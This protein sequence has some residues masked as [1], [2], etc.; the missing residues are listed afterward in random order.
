LAKTAKKLVLHSGRHQRV[1]RG[2]AWVFSNEAANLRDGFEP[3]EEVDVIAASGQV[4]GRGY[5]NPHSLI[6][7]RLVRREA[8]ELDAAFFAERLE[9]ARRLREELYPGDTC[10]RLVYGESDGLPGLVIDRYGE[11]YV[12]QAP[13]AGM[14]RLLP[15]VLEALRH[16][17]EPASVILRNDGPVVDL[18]GLEREKRVLFGAFPRM[19]EV[20]LEGMALHVD[21]WEGQ[22]TGLYLDQRENRGV[23]RGVAPGARVLDCFAYCGLW[24]L[25][26]ARWGAVDCLALDSSARALAWAAD[27]AARNGLAGRCRFEKADVFTHLDRLGRRERF[28]VV[29]LDPPALAH[30]GAHL[31]K[32]RSAYRKLNELAL[33][34]VE[35]GGRLVTCSCSYH[36][37][38]ED[39]REII[40]RAAGRARR[41]AAILQWR[42]QAC[43]HPVHPSMPETEYLKC[44]VLKVW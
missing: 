20:E 41:E 16:V 40:A 43:D 3:G 27:N 39:F 29:V 30:S 15:T 6:V 44:V 42:G 23:L 9:R 38:R 26:A 36:I 18:E 1:A 24:S 8:K 25:A 14:R 7:A 2:H 21:P 5:I 33:R 12:L 35:P 4:L 37:S 34:L 11:H 19:V 22:K 17:C 31:P 32:A 28:D 10:H 13:T